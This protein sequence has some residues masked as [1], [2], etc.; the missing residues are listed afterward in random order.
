MKQIIVCISC[1]HAKNSVFLSSD[2]TDTADDKY[3][4]FTYSFP[5]SFNYLSIIRTVYGTKLLE[6]NDGCYYNLIRSNDNI[7][8][9]NSTIQQLMVQLNRQ[10]FMAKANLEPLTD[11]GESIDIGKLLAREDFVHRRLE[12][13]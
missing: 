5:H 7:G 6:T 12:Y 11:R 10:R 8:A 4:T 1:T 3:V 9:S 2:I 13:I